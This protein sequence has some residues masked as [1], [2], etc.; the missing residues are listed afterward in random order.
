M[1]TRFVIWMTILLGVTIPVRA[2]ENHASLD[3]FHFLAGLSVTGAEMGYIAPPQCE[4]FF[5]EGGEQRC[6]ELFLD[7]TQAWSKSGTTHYYDPNGKR[8][9]IKN[10]TLSEALRAFYAP[11]NGIGATEGG[12]THLD[13]QKR[14]SFVAGIYARSYRDGAFH[15]RPSPALRATLKILRAEGC[16]I[17]HLVLSEH[18]V[19]NTMHFQVKPSKAVADLFAIVD[20]WQPPHVQWQRK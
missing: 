12:L 5:R 13:R 17:S 10:R 14:L 20:K 16:Q 15:G 8:L 11:P 3:S 9:V 19:P 6:A 2:A 7:A 4:S 18:E 1:R